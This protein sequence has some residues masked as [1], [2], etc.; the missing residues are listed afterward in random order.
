M[1]N[2]TEGEDETNSV[3]NGMTTIA[4]KNVEVAG[5]HGKTGI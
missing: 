4:E 2:M 1:R 5:N 3:E